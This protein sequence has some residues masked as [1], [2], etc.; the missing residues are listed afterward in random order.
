MNAR[1]D[2]VPGEHA[3]AP[4]SRRDFLKTTLTA[5]GLV[6]A[7]SI[8]GVGR[9]ARAQGGAKPAPLPAANAFLKIGSDNSVTVLLSHSEMGQ[10]IWTALPML[11]AEEL[12]CDWSRVKVEH[13]PTAPQYAHTVYGMQMTGGSSTT[14]SEFDRYR[15]VG[16]LAR[17]LLIQAAAAQWKVAVSDCHVADGV[18]TSGAHRASYGE[19]AAAAAALTPPSEVKLKPRK[20]WTLIGKPTK[21]LDTPEKITGRA[22]FGMDVQFDGLLTAVLARAPVFGGKVKSFDATAAK[23]V[24]GVHEVVQVPSGIAVLADNYWAA[25]TG[26]DALKVDWDLGANAGLDTLKMRAEYRQLAKTAGS[27]ASAKGD[28]QAALV[29]AAKK[30]EAEYELPYLAHATMEPLNCTVKLGENSCEI[31]TGTQFQTGDQGAAAHVLG[32]KPE[33]VTIHTMFLGGGFGRRA[34]PASDFVVEAVEVAKA[35]KKPVKVVWTREDDMRGG[36]YRPMWLHHIR[37]ALDDK[38]AI[39]GWHDVIVGQSII[40]G[41]PFAAVM[42]KDGIDA[43]SVEGAADSPYLKNV[44]DYLVELHS[45]SPGIPVLWWRSVGNTHTAFV[46]ESFIDELAHAAKQDPLAF[47]RALLQKAGAKRHLAVLN[48]AA[49]K[50]GWDKPLAKGHARG[51][52]VHE[53]FGSYVAQVAE[54]SVEKGKIRVH[55]VVAAID[56]GIFVNPET[57]RAQLEGG[58][59]Y[60]L[61][62][63]LHGEIT[64][65]DGHVVQSNFHDYPV[66]RMNEMPKIEVHIVDSGE[67][68]GGVGEPGTPPIAPAVANALFALNGKRLRTLPFK[69]V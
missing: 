11:I 1:I 32:L 67:K 7:F 38:G 15:Q 16:A 3:Q 61:S 58:I 53:S 12:A 60:G 30:V 24:K 55:R 62:A 54:V 4:R 46:V 13:A 27:K 31:W 22:K 23:A 21:R 69:L 14:W 43:T 48:E 65:K 56:C 47:R 25:K 51:V 2:D 41:T 17:E 8:P 39:L 5:A 9:F 19:L 63:A 44:A 28:V 45:P 20:D 33:Q 35:A 49:E 59:V 42:I 66:L 52:A 26:R 64:F 40:A 36:Y 18:I 57:I 68:S 50:F 10:G 29:N 6:I 37:A 34:N